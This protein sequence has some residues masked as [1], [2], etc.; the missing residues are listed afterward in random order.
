MHPARISATVLGCLIL[1]GAVFLTASAW[2]PQPGQLLVLAAALAPWSIPAFVVALVALW[3][4]RANRWITWLGTLVALVGLAINLVWLV[5]SFSKPDV[6]RSANLRI[7]QFNTNRG[8]ADP[9]RVKELL[10][11]TRPD[12]FVM[13]EAT[14]E[15]LKELNSNGSVG[16]GGIVPEYAEVPPGE[17]LG[18]V[19][20][21]KYPITF[22]TSTLVSDGAYQFR[23]HAPT[24][25]TLITLHPA[26]PLVAYD[27]WKRDFA[28]IKEL[29]GKAP[30][31][32]VVVGDFNITDRNQVMREL[33]ASKL[34]D[35]AVAAGSGWQP[36]WPA[37]FG[38]LAALTLDHVLI[39]NELKALRTMTVS[40]PGS[41]H[42]AL[43]AD[44]WLP[45]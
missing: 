21:S 2:G 33:L 26:E 29:I 36:T 32:L 45:A 19:T 39:S 30:D 23:V 41:D 28:N 17:M 38:P 24:P 37:Q 35:A 3:L 22:E 27:N 18:V 11:R 15:F 14:P 31:P 9:A 12:V 16:P 8:A 40:V 43:V 44:L 20:Y 25:F 10:Q 7:L 4:G 1:A 34:Q 5:P 6:S 13:A 42:L